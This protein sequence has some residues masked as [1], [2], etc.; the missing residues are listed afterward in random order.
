MR[1]VAASI[2]QLLSYA[3]T[4]GAAVFFAQP[5]TDP[6]R[7]GAAALIAVLFEGLF[8][9]MKEAVFAPGMGNKTIGVIGFLI[10]GIVNAGGVMAFAIMILTFGPVAAMLGMAEVNLADPNEALF[11]SFLISAF[12]GFV[13]SVAPHIL[14]REGRGRGTGKAA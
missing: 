2:L 13:L 4:L 6:R 11:V 7:W 14:W 9:G 1:R 10:D 8:F 3:A 5:G 12:F